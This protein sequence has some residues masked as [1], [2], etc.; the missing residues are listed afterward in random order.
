MPIKLKVYI[1]CDPA[2]SYPSENFS[3]CTKRHG[4]GRPS[5]EWV[6]VAHPYSG[7]HGSKMT[8]YSYVDQPAWLQNN[9]EQRKQKNTYDSV[10]II[11]N[12]LGHTT[13]WSIHTAVLVHVHAHTFYRGRHPCLWHS[14][15]LKSKQGPG[16]KIVGVNQIIKSVHSGSQKLRVY[17]TKTMYLLEKQR[18][19]AE[20]AASQPHVN[21]WCLLVIPRFELSV[22]RDLFLPLT[23]ILALS[24]YKPKELSL[25]GKTHIPMW[26]RNLCFNWN[27]FSDLLTAHSCSP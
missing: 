16:Q 1:S 24:D 18:P 6:T 25:T 17:A 23:Q 15:C 5:T 14:K 7:T 10:S 2:S 9:T 27:C 19:Q 4:Q 26:R 8:D 13:F 11:K 22:L 21:C 3:V 20:R 12:A